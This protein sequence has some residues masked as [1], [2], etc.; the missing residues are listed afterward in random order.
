MTS[1]K[2]RPFVPELNRMNFLSEVKLLLLRF[3]VKKVMDCPKNIFP[4]SCAMH[5][6]LCSRFSLLVYNVFKKGVFM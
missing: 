2:D 5:I 6:N 4:A 3:N 1:F